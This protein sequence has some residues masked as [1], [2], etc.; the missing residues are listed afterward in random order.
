MVRL[1]GYRRKV[2]YI[3]VRQNM[4]IIGRASEQAS[5]K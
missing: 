1:A 3:K 4:K 5:L 2:T